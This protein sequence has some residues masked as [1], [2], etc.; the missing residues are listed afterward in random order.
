MINKSL[1][2]KTSL[3]HNDVISNDGVK[4]LTNMLSLCYRHS[5]VTYQ[6]T[7]GM[8]HLRR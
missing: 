1:A 7:T 6:G 2:L 5:L 8:K 3:L 4:N